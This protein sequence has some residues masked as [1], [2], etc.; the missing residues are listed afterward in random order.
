MSRKRFILPL[1]ALLSLSSFLPYALAGEEFVQES[2]LRQGVNDP[3]AI[4]QKEVEW[5]QHSMELY[6]RKKD[7]VPLRSPVLE[8]SFDVFTSKWVT[9]SIQFLQDDATS[10]SLAHKENGSVPI[11]AAKS[12][13]GKRR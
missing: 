1:L 9:D 10:E 6:R 3:A 5:A 13:R 4:F 8:S 12:L 11:G 2:V 7:G